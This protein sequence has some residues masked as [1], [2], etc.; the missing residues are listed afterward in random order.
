MQTLNEKINA[1][2]QRWTE[3][4]DGYNVSLA[5]GSDLPGLPRNARAVLEAGANN[6]DEAL[7]LA[8]KLAGLCGKNGGMIDGK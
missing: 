4:L 7:R 8:E 2:K 5:P 6:R 3:F 1:R